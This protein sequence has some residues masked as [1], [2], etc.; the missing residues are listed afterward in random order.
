MS[1]ALTGGDTKRVL[2]RFGIGVIV[3][4]AEGHAVLV[5]RRAAEIITEAGTLNLRDRRL[6]ARSRADN[7]QL[8]KL[9]YRDPS[10]SHAAWRTLLLSRRERAAP[11][12]I[13]VTSLEQEETDPLR[14]KSAMVVCLVDPKIGNTVP[15]ELL[16]GLYSLTR[17]E[18]KLLAAL[19]QERALPAAAD[20]LNITVN[21]ARSY[22]KRIFAKTGTRNQCELV[23]IV[24]TGLA[25]AR[26][27]YPRSGVAVPR[28]VI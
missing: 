4:D 2:D 1:L 21:T 24:L 13:L 17:R 5:N 28:A 18:A 23:G 9:L 22:L 7:L 12:M 8:Q 10:A 27:D 26:F 25:W 11:V 6:L 19:I 16:S 15:E 20:R 14:S 3:L